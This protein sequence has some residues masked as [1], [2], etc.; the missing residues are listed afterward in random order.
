MFTSDRN[1]LI[2]AVAVVVAVAAVV[3]VL[4][5]LGIGVRDET[6][7]QV[8]PPGE[9]PGDGPAKVPSREELRALGLGP[10]PPV[11]MPADNP[12]S[13][14]KVELGKLRLFRTPRGCHFRVAASADKT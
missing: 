13:Q 12:A 1:T 11:I 3:A 9:D 5:L 6:I 10:L 7:R 8:S 2:F 4:A 14:A